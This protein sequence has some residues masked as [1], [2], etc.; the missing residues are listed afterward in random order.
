MLERAG[1]QVA[2]DPLQ[3]DATTPAPAPGDR[4]RFDLHQHRCPSTHQAIDFAVAVAAVVML[5]AMH[6]GATED[7]LTELDAR[8]VRLRQNDA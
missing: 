7:T 2:C 5:V 3:A 8:A 4:A 6:E 1:E